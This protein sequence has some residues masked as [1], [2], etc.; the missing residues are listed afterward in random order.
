MA[1]RPVL[2][3]GVGLGLALVLVG[4]PA[5]AAPPAAR[6][7]DGPADVAADVDAPEPD[8]GVEPEPEPEPEPEAEPQ[9]EPDVER[10]PVV[11]PPWMP[12]HRFIYRNLTAGR[13]N[14]QGLVNETT[15]GYR[16]QL[17]ARNTPLFL[18]SF[19]L[20]GA[21]AFVTPAFIRAGP[22]I[23]IQP[24]AVINFGA[25]YDIVGTFGT[26]RQ[27][28]SFASAT[29]RWGPDDLERNADDDR[30]YSSWGHLITL[31]ALLQARVKNIVV[32][33]STKAYWGD[34]KLRGGDRVYYDQSL[35]I[36]MPDR[37]WSI[38]NET[39][40][41]YLF[42]RLRLIVRHSLTHAFYERRH[43]DAAEP[44][45]RPNGPTSRLGPA[46]AFT[47]FDRPGVRFNRPTVFLLTQWWLRHRW[48]TG[49]QQHAAI[50]YA[51]L[52]FSFEGDL[53]P[54]RKDT[55]RKRRRAR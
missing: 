3:S 4:R 43:F 23:E 37:G 46:V 35:D 33:T 21:H 5:H 18:D 32:R 45:S 41:V 11:P 53:V 47:F 24:A 16:A 40:V 27:L 50:P 30:N 9:P 55:D 25:T 22:T 17:V 1:R 19:A 51:A 12:R 28:Q 36:L 14:P 44:V 6:D 26:F 7:Y 2:V 54:H 15:L 13:V 8:V 42:T 38:M 20:V 34:M 49:E 52:G 10:Q 48:R 39:D 29:D 31:S